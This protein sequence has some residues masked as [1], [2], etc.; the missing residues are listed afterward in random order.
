LEELQLK[1]ERKRQKELEEAK[2]VLMGKVKKSEIAK[3]I[4][5]RDDGS[6]KMAD[7]RI[8]KKKVLPKTKIMDE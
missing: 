2:K 1:E 6:V 5:L 7:G 8:L 4:E 3:K